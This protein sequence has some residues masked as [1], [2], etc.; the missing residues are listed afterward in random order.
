MCAKPGRSAAMDIVPEYGARIA[1]D[2]KLARKMKIVVDS[3][4]GIP[5]ASARPSCVRWAAR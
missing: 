2:R 3:G 4:N 1:G 5:G